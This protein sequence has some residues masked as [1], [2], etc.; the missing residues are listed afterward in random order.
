MKI[1][2]YVAAVT[3]LASA[4]I[5]FA[6]AA[7]VGIAKSGEEGKP[8][9]KLLR[10]DAGEFDPT[11]ET[12][13]SL[14]G[15]LVPRE[16]L[17]EPG[18]T[19]GT[20]HVVQFDGPITAAMHEDLKLAGV[21]V[22][23]YL[24]QDALLVRRP[25]GSSEASLAS[26]ARARFSGPY[27]PAYKISRELR[28]ALREPA[29]VGGPVQID[30]M[31]FA[32]EDAAALATSL[33]AKFAREASVLAV[34]KDHAPRLLI[35]IGPDGAAAVTAAL[36]ADDAVQYVGRFHP[37]ELH[38]DNSVWI[39]QSYDRVNGPS[40]AQS[41]A[42]P[43]PYPLSA[44]VWN[45]GLRG[46][47][48][49]IAVADTGLEY[50]MCFFDDPSQTVVPQAVTAPAPVSLNLSHRK[51]LAYNYPT[52][53][54]G[55]PAT[56]D[57]AFRHGT[58]VAGSVAGDDLAHPAGPGGAGH[59]HG[60]G[61]APA[62]KLL[63]QDVGYDTGPLCTGNILA[64]FG[65]LPAMLQQD[66]VAGARIATHSYG[67]GNGYES[68]SADI[69]GV[70]W[71]F[72]DLTV[73]FSAGNTG[74]QSSP[75]VSGQ[76]AA[77][78]TIAVG[79]SETYGTNLDPENMAA[80]SSRG[81]PDG[82]IK[83]DLV[84]PG[85]SV[86][87]GRF[88][89][90]YTQDETG[91]SGSDPNHCIPSFGGC[92]HVT[93]DEC[94]A[95]ALSGTSMASPTA[96]GLAALARQY[97]TDGFYPSGAA[98]APA[99]RN[100]SSALVKAVLVNGARTMTGIDRKTGGPLAEAPTSIQGWGRL[101]LDDALYF[102]GDARRLKVVDLANAAGLRTG[103]QV[104]FHANVTSAG[105][106]LE[107]TLVWTDPP[108]NPAAAVDLVHDLDLE[109]TGPDG[110]VYR[111][112]QWTTDH[113]NVPGDKVSAAN[114]AGRDSI[115]NIEGVLI[116]APQ[117][118]TYLVRILGT[119]VPGYQ[120]ILAQGA[121]IVLTG[122]V[123]S[124]TSATPPSLS[125]TGLGS[126]R[127]DLAWTAVPGAL[128]YSL[129]RNRTGC[130]ESLAADAV[131]SVPAGQN[132]YSD[133][134]VQPNQL[135]NYTVRA[136]M[137][138]DGCE[139]AD[140]NC[141]SLTTNP[142]PSI[143]SVTPGFG[144]NTDPTTIVILGGGFV[145]GSQVFLGTD[146]Q[147]EKSPLA[148]SFV[149]GGQL[150]AAVPVNLLPMRYDVRVRVPEGLT[151]TANDAFAVAAPLQVSTAYV[152]NLGPVGPS[153]DFLS[154]VGLPQLGLLQDVPTGQD[155]EN[156]GIAVLGSGQGVLLGR[157]GAPNVRLF[158]PLT[159]EIGATI[160]VAG[161]S[162][163]GVDIAIHPDGTRAFMLAN[164]QPGA[165]KV[166]DLVNRT[167][168]AVIP[169]G[170]QCTCNPPA[171]DDL[172]ISNDGTRVYVTN[173]NDDTISVIDTTSYVELARLTVGDSPR[174]LAVAN[175]GRRVYVANRAS[176]TISVVDASTLQ[177]VE[178]INASI[179]GNKMPK[180][181]AVS[182]DDLYLFVG[183]END[184]LAKFKLGPN[185]IG[186]QNLQYGHWWRLRYHAATG[187]LYGLLRGLP[188][189]V[190]IHPSTLA[191][192][193]ENPLHVPSELTFLDPIPLTIRSVTSNRSCITGGYYHL[194]E[195]TGFQ[196]TVRNDAGVVVQ[197][198]TRVFYGTQE[199]NDLLLETSAR[200]YARVP[201]SEVGATP[202]D[203]TV[204][205]PNGTSAT[206]P[207]GLTY[208][209]CGGGVSPPG[210]QT[211]GCSYP[212]C[213]L[214]RRR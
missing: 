64:G 156:V 113:V 33:G 214:M 152:A 212:P 68:D 76:A 53:S 161:G 69:D 190:R 180:S 189:M 146:A 98:S 157:L 60:D 155:N 110:T 75:F 27:R 160:N 5:G 8:A 84:V 35:E 54:L 37:P 34:R 171:S 208:Q 47:G 209:H 1:L 112:N 22:L 114:P 78:N 116:P 176:K 28:A 14:E 131:I 107:A 6:G 59:N 39:G 128:G 210:D 89:T 206:L 56:G 15:A 9:D 134:T 172:A 82:R 80:F 86:V 16:A 129:L 92:Y 164:G 66:H 23:G 179:N 24:P 130:G 85:V 20:V 122:A 97:F 42:E 142:A 158:N 17:R 49:V 144:V 2:R 74:T 194:I 72:P 45:R 11:R 117:V 100:P 105:Q 87:S 186:A 203:V 195:G 168:I 159:R 32:G 96:A 67:A 48:Q 101:T 132:T 137:A 36:L 135:Y 150:R 62:A 103:A 169:V 173:E 183:Y 125:I 43:N 199:S 170:T 26:V 91:C 149:S 21:E 193:A 140:S 29:A 162:S 185:T 148:T 178:T 126:L 77:K 204:Q 121:S 177:V 200:L 102:S 79:A 81:T 104:R 13:P 151:A 145:D 205:N 191:I 118:G 139:T 167:T 63:I 166:L 119:S 46:E 50:D 61:M 31:L 55:D 198:G 88:P 147:P 71:Q 138:A 120:G 153:A 83:P 165:V 133:T 124:C 127:V 187:K 163:G 19:K 3:L 109:V 175:S 52:G 70:A 211:P 141:A 18:R 58:H 38:N 123:D 182:D 196:G 99:S 184:A 108:G 181:V 41:P 12:G 25:H 213:D 10:L 65:I 111:G 154:I 136:V 57:G 94:A 115:N 40:E 30:V 93:I 201:A 7:S 51:V 95:L 207:A 188:K 197:Q 174:G 90:S 143:Q 73:F 4:S 44:T 106:P 202:V 192:E